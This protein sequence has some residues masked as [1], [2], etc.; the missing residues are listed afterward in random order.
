[1]I[2][3]KEE[4]ARRRSCFFVFCFDLHITWICFIWYID[5]SKLF[6]VFLAL[7]QYFLVAVTDSRRWLLHLQV[8][9]WEPRF[10]LCVTFFLVG[11]DFDCLSDYDDSDLVTWIQN[12]RIIDWR[13][14]T[15][16]SLFY[17]NQPWGIRRQPIFSQGSYNVLH[18]IIFFVFYVVIGLRSDHWF[19][20]SLRPICNL[21]QYC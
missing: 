17:I 2:I 14:H 10:P 20:L 4:E 1:M 8:Y 5:L 19:A 9:T 6:Y 3:E 13:P 21:V 7:C 18:L 12:V 11:R 15:L 16:K